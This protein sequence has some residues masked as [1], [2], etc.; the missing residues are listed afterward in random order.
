MS[1]SLSDAGAIL[2]L[3]LDILAIW[4]LIYTGFSVVRNNLSLIHI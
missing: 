3:L 1:V 4:A 2:R